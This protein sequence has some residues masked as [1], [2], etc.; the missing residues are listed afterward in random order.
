VYFICIFNVYVFSISASE[1]SAAIISGI[2]VGGVVVVLVI[3]VGIVFMA[4]KIHTLD[5]SYS[6][7]I[8]GNEA[9]GLYTQPSISKQVSQDTKDYN[10]YEKA[11]VPGE[12]DYAL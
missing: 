1:S 8:D 3:L 6:I 7:R 11:P 12:G 4:Y 9:F 2:V 10:E 5:S